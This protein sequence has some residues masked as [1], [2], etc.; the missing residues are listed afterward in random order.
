V[1]AAEAEGDQVNA[2]QQKILDVAER[3]AIAIR[4]DELVKAEL[5]KARAAVEYAEREHG[6]ALNARSVLVGELRAV[7]LQPD[8]S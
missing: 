2:R 8:E 3:L 1:D 6:L 5:I 7:L 4:N